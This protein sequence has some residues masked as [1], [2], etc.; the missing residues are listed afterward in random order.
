MS[1]RESSEVPQTSPESGS[2]LRFA[3]SIFSHDTSSSLALVPFSASVGNT[4]ITPYL[5]VGMS[6]PRG[7]PLDSHPNSILY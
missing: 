6:L 1:N 4:H 3:P 2:T 5:R 7:Y